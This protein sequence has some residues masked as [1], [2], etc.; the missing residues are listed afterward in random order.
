MRLPPV[1]VHFEY[2]LVL[3]WL[4]DNE[5]RRT[6][7]EL[8]QFLQGLPASTCLVRCRSADDVRNALQRAFQLVPERGI[9][10]VHIE[11]HGSDPAQ[12]DV[13]DAAFGADAAPGLP[14]GELGS[15][16]APLNE[17]SRFRLLV[18]G[19]TCFG[20]AAIAAMTVGQHVAP[21]AAVVGFTTTV[22]PGS[23]HDAM[24]EL[25]RS[26]CQRRESLQD[27]AAAAQRELRR[28]TE[29]VRATSAPLLAIRILRGVYDGIRPGVA[30]TERARNLMQTLRE[31]GLPAPLA[32]G[33]MEKALLQV[34]IPR[35]NE[36]WNAWFPE[37]ARREAAAYQLDSRWI[38]QA[39]LD[40]GPGT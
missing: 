11:S 4:D 22:D 33:H 29:H 23:L 39:E 31:A 26:I 17:A 28:A 13:R 8:H 15:W 14:W 37:T 40:E 27:A 18:V 21:F 34:G 7:E 1:P 5:P 10:V 19:A 6:G 9:P 25:Y 3:E 24:R 20:L 35:I 30:L 38:Q 36:T 16:L 2:V 32:G 12:G